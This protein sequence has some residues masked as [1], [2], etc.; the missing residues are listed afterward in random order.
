MPSP[1]IS[2]CF[3]ACFKTPAGKQVLQVLQNMTIY[4]Q[5]SPSITNDELRCLEGER[6]LMFKI[7]TFI[8][9]GEQNND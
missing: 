2:S 3:S 7:L 6:Q 8:K 1:E 5:T 4:R 9:Q